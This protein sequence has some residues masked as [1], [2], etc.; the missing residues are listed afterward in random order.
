MFA[1]QQQ[2]PLQQEE[3]IH[4]VITDLHIFGKSTKVMDKYTSGN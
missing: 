2:H 1:F 4:A 3:Q